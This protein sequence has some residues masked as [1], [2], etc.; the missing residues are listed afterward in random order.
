MNNPISKLLDELRSINFPEALFDYE[1]SVRLD[2]ALK[3]RATRPNCPAKSLA[4]Y[5]SDPVSLETYLLQG[6]NVGRK[7][8]S[9]L[10]QR[11]A[12]LLAKRLLVGGFDEQEATRISQELLSRFTDNLATS[13]I[14]RVVTALRTANDSPSDS[15]VSP[16][17]DV[18]RRSF[19]KLCDTRDP[20]DVIMDLLSEILTVREVDILRRRYAV[21]RSQCQTLE[22]VAVV[23]ALTRERIRQIQKNALKKCRRPYFK[24]YFR[25]YLN[26][27]VDDVLSS[28][29][30]DRNILPSESLKD[31]SRALHEF[32]SCVLLSVDVAYN[33]LPEWLDEFL[34][35]ITQGNRNL[36]WVRRDLDPEEEKKTVRWLEH[37]C[38]VDETWRVQLKQVIASMEWP[39]SVENLAAKCPNLSTRDIVRYLRQKRGAV[40]ENGR[41]V[42][43][44][45]LST[46]IRLVYVLRAAKG[47]LHTRQIRARHNAMFGADVTE[48]AIGATLQRL[49]NVL[50][51]KRGYYDL[52]ENLP[53]DSSAIKGLCDEILAFV[54]RRGEYVSAKVIYKE[55]FAS[56]PVR[57]GA[58]LTDYMV[59]GF[60]QDDTR[61][62]V[63]RGLMIGLATPSFERTF[64]SLNQTIKDIV[65]EHGP[66]SVSNIQ[67]NIQRHR[68]VLDV[69]VS[70]LLRTSTEF[71][72]CGDGKYDIL[73][74]VIGDATRCRDLRLAIE[75]CLLPGA[76]SAYRLTER[77]SYLGW[78]LN[79]N[80]VYS[81]CTSMPRVTVNRGVIRLESQ[82]KNV[83]RYEK[84]FETV[85]DAGVAP[86]ENRRRMHS[87][88]ADTDLQ[89]LVPLD[90][91][92]T[93][94][95]SQSETGPTVAAN[96][97]EII[98]DLLNQFEL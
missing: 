48:H 91:R 84:L 46:S 23:Y 81:F 26:K 75:I 16:A 15:E 74:R 83:R 70:L 56:N 2:S 31:F 63:R 37:T 3:T 14:E 58:H 36:G 68:D 67:K 88:L 96:D 94:G 87:K 59:L 22:E 95:Y 45:K 76:Q 82:G 57:H 1:L 8:I 69:T 71:V 42:R 7:T 73:R 10:K 55:L 65:T 25:R 5:L 89:Q 12:N 11:L 80:T 62:S 49:K 53:I 66:I 28:V 19:E 18:E 97:S 29:F 51:V 85:F 72:R 79:K 30:E 86:E 52:Y 17:V 77:L 9:E 93:D 47:P 92:L 43:M 33:G 39:I 90:F 54:K 24:D 38:A 21:N 34:K 20:D 40:I 61:F 35:P 4:A 78:D 44:A 13:T 27:K 6:R 50:I 98:D 60:V 32:S 64:V 41:V